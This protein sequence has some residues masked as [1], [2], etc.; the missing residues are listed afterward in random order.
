LE[1]SSNLIIH[2]NDQVIVRRNRISGCHKQ[3]L[4]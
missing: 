2:I 1:L 4:R 3:R